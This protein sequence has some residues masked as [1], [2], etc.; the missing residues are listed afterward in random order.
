MKERRT[1]PVVA[2]IG[3]SDQLEALGWLPDRLVYLTLRL[4]RALANHER[5]RREIDLV[6]A[7]RDRV[8]EQIA[9]VYDP[10]GDADFEEYDFEEE[11]QDGE[12]RQGD[13]DSS[14]GVRPRSA[15]TTARAAAI[16]EFIGKQKSMTASFAEVLAEL[17]RM[18]GEELTPNHATAVLK[19]A[20][21][22]KVSRG[23]YGL[24]AADRQE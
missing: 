14:L 23:V 7:E 10:D 22:T 12:P 16:A 24:R 15:D 3:H 20:Q 11:R 5:V 2:G 18:F 1:V 4:R 6:R 21:F 19:R 9:A 13:G 17:R 8:I